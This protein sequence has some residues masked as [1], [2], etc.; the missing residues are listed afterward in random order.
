LARLLQDEVMSFSHDLPLPGI[1]KK[2]HHFR[3]LAKQLH[4][5]GKKNPHCKWHHFT[6]SLKHH[7]CIANNQNWELFA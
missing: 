6:Y 1:K 3:K 7:L 5:F 2:L 4:Q